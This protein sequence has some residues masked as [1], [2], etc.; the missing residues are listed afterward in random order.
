MIPSEL[1][2]PEKSSVPVSIRTE[3]QSSLRPMILA[4]EK[5]KL[6]YWYFRIIIPLYLFRFILHCP[7]CSNDFFWPL[8][9]ELYTTFIEL[10]VCYLMNRDFDIK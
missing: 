4:R 1:L 10:C 5:N 8:V 3:Y 7:P 6:K 9:V 2:P